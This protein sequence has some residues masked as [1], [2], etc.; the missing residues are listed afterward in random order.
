MQALSAATSDGT[1]VWRVSFYLD[2]IYLGE[3]ADGTDGFALDVDLSAYA[4]GVHQLK[5]VAED[6]SGNDGE[7]SSVVVVDSPVVAPE[8][9][10]TSPSPGSVD[11]TLSVTGTVSSTAT[12][13]DVLLDDTKIASVAP[14]SGEFHVEAGQWTSGDHTVT[15][16]AY[17]D[18]GNRGSSSVKVSGPS[19][20]W[21]APT[22]AAVSAPA[23]VA[24]GTTAAVSADV[25]DNRSVASA[26]LFYRA[27]GS[28]DDFRIEPMSPGPGGR[29]SASIPRWDVTLAGIEY[30]V[31]ASDW[32]GNMATSP[33][34]APAD[35]AKIS[36]R[37]I[38]TSLAIK[39]TPTAVSYGG[40][41]TV[42]VILKDE[43]GRPLVGRGV[44][45]DYR[46]AGVSTWSS[47][48]TTAT[49]A[50]G[51]RPSSSSAA[52]EHDLPRSVRGKRGLRGKRVLQR[53]GV[54]KGLSE[55]GE[56]VAPRHPLLPSLRND[57]AGTCIVESGAHLQVALRIREVEAVQLRVLPGVELHVQRQV[58]VPVRR[59]MARAGG[60]S[61]RPLQLLQQDALHRV[62]RE[63]AL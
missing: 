14:E 45:L 33:S 50:S 3:D 13:V 42:S 43:F 62:L 24:V 39:V 2:D 38:G 26:L 8:V 28:S 47:M 56:D 9:A 23:T 63:I 19:P 60:A 27:A 48:T 52:E 53:G 36:A 31:W 34:L 46:A 22:I 30:F 40:A 44:A 29:V 16:S 6:P 49:G 7:T 20:D 61:R 54:R 5:A 37:R 55:C 32:D 11:G 21:V 41:C 58:Q 10:I 35:V 4:A 12:R 59:Q 25:F 57:Q 15:V 17:D 1:G 18:A 51:S